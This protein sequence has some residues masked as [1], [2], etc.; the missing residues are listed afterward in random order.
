M[1]PTQSAP[2]PQSAG[3]AHVLVQKPPAYTASPRLVVI[4]QVNPAPHWVDEVHGAPMLVAVPPP[5]PVPP[6]KPPPV[7]PPKP[8]PVPP[9]VPPPIAPP[10]VPPPVP[11]SQAKLVGLQVCPVLVQ[12]THVLPWVPQAVLLLLADLG[13]QV[14]AESQQPPQLV[15]LQVV[16]P[17]QDGTVARR[18]PSAAP[19]TRACTFM[20]TSP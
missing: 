13:T 2:A 4:L 12:S 14:P 17:P 3:A 6:P 8:P 18:K 5:P 20:K 10:P 15:E 9:P 19:R 1:P 16:L 11:P 7:P